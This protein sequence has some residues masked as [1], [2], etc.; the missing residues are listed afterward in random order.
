MAFQKRTLHCQQRSQGHALFVL[1]DHGLNSIV[2]P[3]WEMQRTES[4]TPRHC[5]GLFNASKTDQQAVKTCKGTAASAR[6]NIVSIGLRIPL[7][8]QVYYGVD[9]RGSGAIVDSHAPTV[10]VRTFLVGRIGQRQASAAGWWPIYH[11]LMRLQH[12][13]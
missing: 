7:H 4:L 12:G 2:I 11:E 13:D 8:Q 5:Q 6:L 3:Y 1:V 9:L 10:K